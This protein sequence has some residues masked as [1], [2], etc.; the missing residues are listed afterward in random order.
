M[1]IHPDIA[2]AFLA[3]DDSQIDYY[4]E[5]TKRMPGKVLGRHDL[6]EREGDGYRLVPDVRGFTPEQRS[7]LVRLCDE[8]VETYRSRRGNRIFHHRRTALGDISG[9]DRYEVLKRAGR[10]CELCGVP[11]EERALEVDHIVPRRY[12]GSDDRSNL[13]ALCWRC[14][15]NKGARDDTDFRHV[16]EAMNARQEG[17]IFCHHDQRPKRAENDLALTICDGHP[18]TP[19]HTLVIPRRHTPSFFDL[20]EPER[21]AINLLLDQVRLDILAEDGTVEGFNIG[22]NSGEIADQTVMH[23][24]VHLIPRRR[25]MSISLGAA[26]GPS[27]QE[28]RRTRT[29]AYRAG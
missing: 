4:A 18:V 17:C 21:R 6:V 7:A 14:N 13:Q 12:G 27:Y 28:G 15:A 5:I 22:M 10:R 16:R 24:H 19:L 3:Q 25:A 26:F 9:S 8:G 11:A 1:G 29:G 2:S 23:C 20:Y